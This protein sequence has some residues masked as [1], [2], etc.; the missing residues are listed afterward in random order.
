MNGQRIVELAKVFLRRAARGDF[1]QE[2]ARDDERTALAAA[3]PPCTDPLVQDYA[4]WRRALLAIAAV[5]LG[6]AVLVSLIAYRSVSGSVEPAAAAVLGE[7]TLELL[8]FV[9]WTLL[10]ANAAGAVCIAL[11]ARAWVDVQRSRVL[12]RR[13]WLIMFLTPLVLAALPWTRLLDFGHLPPE[14][15]KLVSLALGLHLGI[16]LFLQIAPK[17][18]ALFPCTIR[19]AMTLKTLLPEHAAPGWVAA[20]VGPLYAVFL[21]AM[22]TILNQMSGNFVLVGGIACL[23]ISPLVLVRSARDLLRPHTAD[24]SAT[25]VRRTRHASELFNLAGFAL[26]AVW[27]VQLDQFSFGDALH[28]LLLMAGNLTLLTVVGADFVLALLHRGFQQSQA[29][30]GTELAAALAKKFESLSAAG[31]TEVRGRRAPPAASA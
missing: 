13:G 28:F 15:R 30:Q 14:Q 27:I 4:A 5:A 9:L 6:L 3:Q 20:I 29:F 16:S 12:A 8:D 2:H 18:I 21:V 11:A 22:I 23:M 17:A 1:Q 26:F 25:L 24:E 7:S 10:L 31:L 19:S